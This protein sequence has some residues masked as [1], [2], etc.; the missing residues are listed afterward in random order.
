MWRWIAPALSEEDAARVRRDHPFWQAIINL[1]HGQ[2]GRTRLQLAVERGKL[3][4]VEALIAWHADLNAA[5]DI[6]ETTLILASYK[7][8]DEIVRALIAAGAGVD[9]TSNLG[10]TALIV[11]SLNGHVEV[12]RMLLAAG[13]GVD[14]ANNFG[15]TALIWTSNNGHVEVVR[16]LAAGAGVD[17]ACNHGETALICASYRGYVEIVRTLLAAGLQQ[18]PHLR[19]RHHGLQLRFSHPCLDRGHPRAPRPRALK[20]ST[21]AHSRSLSPDLEPSRPPLNRRCLSA[22][23]AH[24]KWP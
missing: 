9:A 18:A 10:N 3:S 14:A 24:R 7:G 21:G 4:H 5:T 12:V 13:A 23:H 16:V 15:C 8:Y 19:Q 1:R 2:H 20:P 22:P 11:A 6:D 17:A